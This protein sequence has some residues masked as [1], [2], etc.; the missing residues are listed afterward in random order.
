MDKK[1]SVNSQWLADRSAPLLVPFPV[2]RYEWSMWGQMSA[3]SGGP[4]TERRWVEPQLL[5]LTSQRT[6]MPLS[7]SYTLSWLSHTLFDRWRRR[8]SDEGF[9][10]SLPPHSDRAMSFLQSFLPLSLPC[11]SPSPH[12][13]TV[14]PSLSL[15]PPPLLAHPLSYDNLFWL[16][17]SCLSLIQYSGFSAIQPWPITTLH[18]AS[19]WI[20]WRSSTRQTSYCFGFRRCNIWNL[21][22]KG[23][24]FLHHQYF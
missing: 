9:G 22:I 4:Y 5:P 17:T 16:L 24:H 11:P 20:S 2:C 7:L 13:S 14:S 15:S 10:W 6:S 21:K 3:S 1:G 18:L 8:D 12:A 19:P 23:K